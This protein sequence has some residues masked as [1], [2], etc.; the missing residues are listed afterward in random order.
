MLRPRGTEPKRLEDGRY[1][2]WLS[3]EPA[4][5]FVSLA[6]RPSFKAFDAFEAAGAEVFF[7]F[8]GSFWDRAEPAADLLLAPVSLLLR[9]LEAE[10]AAFDEVVLPDM[11]P[12]IRT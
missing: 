2:F 6:E 3:A 9:V 8:V 4:A 1:V 7:V 10:L 11:T 12:S 5:D